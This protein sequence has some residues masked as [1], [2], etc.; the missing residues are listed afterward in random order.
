[1][2]G[3]DDCRAS[4]RREGAVTDHDRGF[5]A[6]AACKPLSW[7]LWETDHYFVYV[8]GI[9]T[10]ALIIG[11]ASCFYRSVDGGGKMF[12]TV[13]DAVSQLERLATWIVVAN[14]EFCRRE[15]V[16]A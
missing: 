15:A 3:V 10:G 2:R 5:V 4:Q 13:Q 12:A 16:Y 9:R 1:M 14:A 8:A 11:A 6:T 7:V